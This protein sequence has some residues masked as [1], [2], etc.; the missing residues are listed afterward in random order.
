MKN[1]VCHEGVM[2]KENRSFYKESLDVTEIIVRCKECKQ[3]VGKRARVESSTVFSVGIMGDDLFIE[4]ISNYPNNTT[5]SLYRYPKKAYHLNK[6]VAASS[7]GEYVADE[8]KP[9]VGTN[10]EKVR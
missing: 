5:I 8:I 6:L 1:I 7:A 10:Y 3:I 9:E 2:T 4:F